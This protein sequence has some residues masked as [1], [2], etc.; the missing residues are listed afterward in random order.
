MYQKEHFQ[1]KQTI[2]TILADKAEFIEIAKDEILKNRLIIENYIAQNPFFEVTLEGYDLDEKAPPMIQKMIEA[3]N[4]F[5]I[6]PMSAVA[7]TIAG[8]AVEKM[9]DSGANFALVD[10]GGDMAIYNNGYKNGN[11][12]L[13]VGVYAGNSSVTDLGFSIEPSDDILGIC[14]S[15]GTVGPSISFGKADAAIIFSKNLPLADSAATALGNALKEEG[16][17]NIEKALSIVSN[18][19][20][21]DGAVLIQGNDIGF[22]GNVPKLMKANVDYDMITKG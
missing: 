20:G 5:D 17:E 3:G 12:P 2:V 15:S 11:K 19:E 9:K 16:A 13:V 4:M 22:V 18:V 21:I 6:G 14:T 10:N 1:Y 8:A 7:G